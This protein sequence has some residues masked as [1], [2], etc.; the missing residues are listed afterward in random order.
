[1]ENLDLIILTI[2]VVIFFL[3]FFVSTF[4]AFE[5]ATKLDNPERKKHGIFSRILNYLQ[6]IVSE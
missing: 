2:I 4:K 6:N 5:Y 1:M 3:A